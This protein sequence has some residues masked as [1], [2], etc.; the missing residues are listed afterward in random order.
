MSRL[1]DDVLQA[2]T[3]ACTATSAQLSAQTLTAMAEHLTK[4][5]AARVNTQAGPKKSQGGQIPCTLGAAYDVGVAIKNLAECSTDAA[6]AT[7]LVKLSRWSAPH[8][9]EFNAKLAAL[10]KKYGKEV[11]EGKWDMPNECADDFTAELKKVRAETVMLN[12][13]LKIELSALGDF[14]VTPKTIEQLSIILSDLD[15]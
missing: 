15:A 14:K 10:L 5:L 13:A 12:S 3:E 9:A 11:G 2:I 6:T 8:F 4:A 1:E 7:K